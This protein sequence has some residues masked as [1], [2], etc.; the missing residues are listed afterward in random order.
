MNVK[1]IRFPLA[2]NEK[3]KK[4]ASKLGRSKVETFVQMVD[5]FY[6]NKKDP[7]DLS[8]QLLKHA[9]LKNHKDYIGFIKTQE[10]ELLIPMK[11][12]GERLLANLKLLADEVKP[13]I[14]ELE[15]VL[16]ENLCKLLQSQ[17]GNRNMI[18]AIYEATESKTQ[19]KARFVTL[20]QQYLN[21]RESLGLMASAKDKADLANNSLQAIKLL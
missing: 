13:M 2:T 11:H 16:S 6:G 15:R 10:H 19:L 12:D 4:I 1:T 5:Y 20:F 17:T 3:L 18:S 8:D 21:A 7:A 14:A 9:L